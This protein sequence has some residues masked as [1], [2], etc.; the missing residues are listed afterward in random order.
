[1]AGNATGNNPF[2]LSH[3]GLENTCIVHSVFDATFHVAI[4]AALVTFNPFFLGGETLKLHGG[5][6]VSLLASTYLSL[7]GSIAPIFCVRA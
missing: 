2:I 5:F 1:M 4:N 7:N 6:S 3:V